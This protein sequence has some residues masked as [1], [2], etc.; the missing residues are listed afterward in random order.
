MNSLLF[1]KA[2]SLP[3]ILQ[4]ERSECGLACLAMIAAHYGYRVD[5][6]SLRDEFPTSSRGAS[7]R[8]LLG[9]AQ[10]L[11]LQARALRLEI[12]DLASLRTPAILHWDMDHFVVLSSVGRQHVIVHDPA[13][14]RRKYRLT[15]LG[16]HFTG[17]A[18]E[19]VPGQHFVQQTRQRRSRLWDLFVRYP[20][21]NSS[22]LQ[23]FVLSLLIQLVGIGSAFY[24]Q[25]VIDASIGRGDRDLLS[26]LALGFSLVM[27]TGVIMQ[28]VRS[29]VQLYFA[30]QLGFQMAGNVLTHLMKLPT[31]FFLKRH[32]GDLVSRF[33]AVR[34]IRNLLSEELITVVLDGVM[35]VLVFAVLLYFDTTLAVLV[36][37]FVALVSLLKLG[38]VPRI[39]A[40]TEQ[41]IIADAKANSTLM[42]NMRAIEMIK[43]YCRELPRI[44]LWR[45]QY[46]QQINASVQ[47]TRFG[48]GVDALYGLIIGL[49]NIVVVYLAAHYVLDGRI[50]LGFMTAF[51]ALKSHFSS[52]VR[53]LIDKLVQIR[54]LRLQLERVSD[55]TCAQEEYADFYLPS[56]PRPCSGR[57]ELQQLCYHYAG[58]ETAVLQGINLQ[59]ASGE[60]VAIVG[61]S[62][63]GKST[64]LKLMA[65]LLHPTHGSLLIDGEPVQRRGHRAYRNAC[66]GVLQTDQLV[67]GTLRENI[68]LYEEHVEQEELQRAARLAGIHEFICT[69]P[70]GYS[71]LVG[72]MGS[73]MS[74]G[75]TQ[76]ILL[77]RAFYK[78]ASVLFLDEATANLDQEVESF[79]LGNIRS[80]GVTTIMITHRPAPLAIATRILHCHGGGVVELPREQWQ[81]GR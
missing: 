59:I 75:Q 21:F 24:L 47:V 18:I 43:F 68:C 36:L 2:H 78:Q 53:S 52:S 48:I 57:M 28:F 76:R 56:P 15:E 17:V 39:R 55:I 50:S 71:S 20:G 1:R 77:A 40:L 61:P 80:L 10:A 7:L 58:D 44:W 79:V 11:H 23:L 8:D 46:A 14:G 25:L 4:A 69:L 65:G 13:L 33:G 37:V 54:L 38:L 3:V 9:T 29:T 31:D 19:C 70:M 22:V 51:L 63:A 6:N 12:G 42:E 67:S 35:A 34:E 74:A 81:P 73:S 66:A 62:G 41:M 16:N 45:H 26:V 49:E 72:D 60:I 27:L 30:N 64:L 32:I 5:L